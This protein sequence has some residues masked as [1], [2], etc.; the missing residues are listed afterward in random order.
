MGDHTPNVVRILSTTETI[1]LVP[2]CPDNAES[3]FQIADSDFSEYGLIDQRSQFLAV[4]HALPWESSKCV[5]VHIS[6]PEVS[7]LYVLR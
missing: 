4:V 3:W 2:Y 7:D 1:Q 5:T 6:T